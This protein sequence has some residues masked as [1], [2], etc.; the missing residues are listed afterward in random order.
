MILQAPSRHRFLAVAVT[1]LIV[2]TTGV[3]CR[4]PDGGGA[5]VDPSPARY[6]LVVLADPDDPYEPLAEE[7]ANANAAPFVH[8]VYQALSLAPD[9]L[10][11]VVSPA[12]LSDA[13]LVAYGDANANTNGNTKRRELS[14]DRAYSRRLLLSLVPPGVDTARHFPIHELPPFAGLV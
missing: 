14:A 7:I 13:A 8:S 10:I 3:L 12:K 9:F 2:W 11:W 4:A 1:A 5:R 6:P